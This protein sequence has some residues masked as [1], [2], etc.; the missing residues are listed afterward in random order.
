LKTTKSLLSPSVCFL[1]LP[2]VSPDEWFWSSLCAQNLSILGRTLFFYG[3]LKL[4]LLPSS[5]ARKMLTGC[6]RYMVTAIINNKSIDSFAK[7]LHSKW[8]LTVRYFH[9]R[10]GCMTCIRLYCL[11]VFK[12]CGLFVL[13]GCYRDAIL[14]VLINLAC[15]FCHE[16]LKDGWSVFLQILKS[17]LTN[18][19]NAEHI[20]YF[21]DIPYKMYKHTAMI[22][23]PILLRKTYFVLRVIPQ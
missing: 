19:F 9:Y 3:F 1:N 12:N 17:N 5:V 10:F 7:S 16:I 8:L 18:R 23:N 13:D 22:L 4:S 20:K 21:M 6:H 14:S 11:I 2:Y 15:V